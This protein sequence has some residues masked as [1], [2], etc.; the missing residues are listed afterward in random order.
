M[1]RHITRLPAAVLIATAAA[2]LV[3]PAPSAAATGAG[4]VRLAHLSPDTPKVDVW[5]T[6]FAGNAYS[7]V[8]RGVGYGAVSPYLRLDPGPY[9][10]SMRAPGAAKASPPMLDTTLTVRD[11]QSYTVAG[12]GP[13]S[14]VSLRVL[15]DDLT[16][17]GPGRARVRVVQ[18][19]SN[20]PEVDVSTT[21]GARLA[22]AAS[23]PSTTPYVAVA[24]R[25]LVLTAGSRM[26]GGRTAEAALHAM[27][28]SVYTVLVLD[29][30]KGGV[31]MLVRLDSAGAGSLPTGAIAAGRAQPQVPAAP[32]WAWVAVALSA[33]AAGGAVVALRSAGLATVAPGRRRRSSARRV[34]GR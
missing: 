33:A 26:A 11:G 34:V 10:V 15:H 1:T 28:G 16:P 17:P 31:W 24:A 7:Q 30:A 21:S 4:Y 19:S 3:L 23:F 8:L 20:V 32:V 13:H 2:V 18:A 27:A 9:T 6:A 29:N 12:I 25:R 14:A 5:L 22:S